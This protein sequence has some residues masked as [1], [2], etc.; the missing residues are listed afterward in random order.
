MARREVSRRGFFGAS[1]AA[2]AAVIAHPVNA[3]AQAAGVKPGDLPDLTIKEAKIYVT[4]PSSWRNAGAGLS[5]GAEIASLVTASGIEG[6]FTLGNRGNPPGWVDFA[7]ATCVGRNLYDILPTV[8][9][10]PNQTRPSGSGGGAGAAPAGRGGATAPAAA[11]AGGGGGRGGAFIGGFNPG[12][13]SR[14]RGTT[15]NVHAAACDFILWDILGKAVNRPIYKIL[16]GTKEK[17][18]AYASSQHLATV[19]DFGPD[20]LKA[21]AAGF[22]AYKIHPGNGQH[23]GGSP[24]P[25]YLG[26]IDEIKEVRK[27]VGDDFTL[28]YD[29]VQ[30]YN[31]YEALRVGR[32]LDEYGY[33]SFEDPMETYDIDGLVELRKHLDVPTEVGEFIISV[34]DYGEFFRRGA[35]GIARLITDNLGGITGSFRVGQMA[36]AFGMP[37]TPHNWGAFFDIAAAFQVELALPNCYWF[38]MPW[39]YEYPDRPYVKYKFR[40]D[41]EGYVPA[42]TE[43][44]MGY[45]LDRAALDKILIRIDR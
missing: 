42:P 41:A 40:P 26:H 45:P 17:V 12:F 13:A 14:P 44:G 35:M 9:Y 19:E 15:P 24:I 30:R 18:L 21:K 3:A 43:P 23:K 39:P 37:C 31:Y 16:G 20:A 8:A 25:A 11:R 29:A 32:A 4:D 34:Y 2:G 5:G 28:L 36:D 6:N 1:A 10:L 33:D 38:E 7:K 27:A 22:K